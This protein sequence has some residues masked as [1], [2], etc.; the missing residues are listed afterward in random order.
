MP[1]PAPENVNEATDVPVATPEIAT[2]TPETIPALDTTI[3]PT[4]ETLPLQQSTAATPNTT[5]NVAPTAASLT[6]SRTNQFGE[7][8]M[9]LRAGSLWAFDTQS[10][11]ER[12]LAEN[13]H[14]FAAAP[15]GTRIA[16]IRKI[17]EQF[18]VWVIQR[19]SNAL[20]QLTNN[21]RTEATLSWAADENALVF[22]SAETADP[23][24]R[25][26][27]QWPQWCATSDVRVFNLTADTE[28]TIADGCDPAISPDGRRIV[29]AAP[30][31]DTQ[32][33]IEGPNSTNT[34]RL[35][36]RQGEN[37]WNFAVAEGEISDNLVRD[38]LL[39]YAPSWSP[40]GSQIVYHRFLGYQ[41]LVDI[42]ITEVSGSFDGQGQPLYGGAGWLLPARVSPN[43]QLIAITEY[44]Y[45]DPRGL[46]GYDLWSVTVMKVEGSHEIPL[47]SRTLDAIG[48]RFDTLPR[49]Q[50]VAWAPNGTTLAVQLP[51]G[52]SANMPPVRPDEGAALSDTGAA[53]E[54]WRW[55]PGELPSERLVENVDAASPIEWVPAVS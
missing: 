22:A 29:F 48:E 42:A 3:E 41:A 32:D 30:P 33:G 13:V 38:G 18:D 55:Q 31:T 24:T 19:D 51:S 21:E 16:L 1:T 17:D 36:N 7:E 14:S 23:Y 27:P 6:A 37:G 50:Q 52:W 5:E 20:T 2:P 39:V 25:T 12:Q 46:N 26:W 53:G 47:P 10:G 28:T 11:R 49:A 45:N 43:N 34:I 40:D 15:D 9:F 54:I 4:D 44:N 35:V 8:I